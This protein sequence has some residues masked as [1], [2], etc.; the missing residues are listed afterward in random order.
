MKFQKKQKNI[1]EHPERSAG[2]AFRRPGWGQYR[3]MIPAAPA[4]S[5]GWQQ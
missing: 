2:S 1:D 5:K 4:I 3:P